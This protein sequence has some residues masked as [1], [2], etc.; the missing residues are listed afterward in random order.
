M[1]I[2]KTDNDCVAFDKYCITIAAQR[3]HETIFWG[4]KGYP[5]NMKG[6]KNVHLHIK[7]IAAPPQWPVIVLGHCIGL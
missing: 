1:A 5:C 7:K 2:L 6:L 3:D 4:E